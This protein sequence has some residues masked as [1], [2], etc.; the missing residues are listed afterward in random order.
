L[1]ASLPAAPPCVRAAA[2][3]QAARSALRLYAA[4]FYS[5]DEQLAASDARYYTDGFALLA[6]DARR[7][8]PLLF[9]TASV[10]PVAGARRGALLADL[11]ALFPFAFLVLNTFPLTPAVLRPLR[12]T[13]WLKADAWLLPSSFTEARQLRLR[14]ARRLF[15]EALPPSPL[16][17][18]AS[19]G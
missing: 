7:A 13:A 12:E 3:A 18:G 14:R 17:V 1:V 10:S 16:P 8:G 2:A 15:A 9:A 5:G 4:T 11:R 6:R 19:C